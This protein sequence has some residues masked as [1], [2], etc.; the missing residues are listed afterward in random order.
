MFIYVHESADQIVV[1]N[2]AQTSAENRFEAST[3]IIHPGMF[4]SAQNPDSIPGLLLVKSL[5]RKF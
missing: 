1:Q 4:M 2:I 3:P 5:W